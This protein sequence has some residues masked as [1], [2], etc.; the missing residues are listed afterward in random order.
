MD[1]ILWPLLERRNPSLQH[2][3][4]YALFRGC[5]CPVSVALFEPR[6]SFTPGK[7]F[8]EEEYEQIE[9]ASSLAA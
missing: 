8:H 5:Q 3:S 9:R 4:D 1:E 6:K 2:F 7:Y